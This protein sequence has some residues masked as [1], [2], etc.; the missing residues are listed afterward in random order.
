MAKDKNSPQWKE[1]S[2]RR[3][4]QTDWLPYTKSRHPGERWKL[5]TKCFS[6]KELSKQFLVPDSELLCISDRKGF[7]STA[8]ALWHVDPSPPAK[9]SLSSCWRAL[10]S[11]DTWVERG[12]L[13]SPWDSI[14]FWQLGLSSQIPLPSSRRCGDRGDLQ[15]SFFRPE[16][17]ESILRE[18]LW[19][20][21]NRRAHVGRLAGGGLGRNSRRGTTYNAPPRRR[22]FDTWF[23]P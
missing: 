22:F 2:L 16:K 4:S 5:C 15:G 6:I 3:K 14:C 18:V 12:C 13:G 8:H 10:L 9:T 17:I 1:F 23:V 20:P 11:G 21:E 19:S 7:F